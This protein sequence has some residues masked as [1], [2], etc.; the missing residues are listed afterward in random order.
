MTSSESCFT[1]VITG[2]LYIRK[3]IDNSSY[4]G[5]TIAGFEESTYDGGDGE[6][7]KVIVQLNTAISCVHVF[8]DLVI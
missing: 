6:I 5:V 1:D 2:N 7:F 4:S 3:L 8:W